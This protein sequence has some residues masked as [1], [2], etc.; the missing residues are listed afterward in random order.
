[1]EAIHKY[2]ER[3]VHHLSFKKEEV[4]QKQQKL[5]GLR[6]EVSALTTEQQISELREVIQTLEID[7]REAKCDLQVHKVQSKPF[8]ATTNTP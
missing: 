1:L 7:L 5:S 2:Q 8:I 3:L 6:L 4:D